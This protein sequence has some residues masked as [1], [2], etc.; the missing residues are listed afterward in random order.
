M[1]S[2]LT[3][4]MILTIIKLCGAGDVDAITNIVRLIIS[5][6]CLATYTYMVYVCYD[7]FRIT[8]S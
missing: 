8:L 5:T 4:S 2:S 1:S 6:V 7:I 3:F